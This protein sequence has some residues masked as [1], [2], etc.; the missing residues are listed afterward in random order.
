[1]SRILILRSG[2]DR[3]SIK[4]NIRVLVVTGVLAVLLATSSVLA[5]TSGSHPTSVTDVLGT[6]VAPNQSELALIVLEIRLPR[7][8]MAILVG[9]AL[10]SAGLI[11]QG[12]VR[13]PL[14]SPDVIGITSGASAAAV[15]FLHRFGP[16]RIHDRGPLRLDWRHPIVSAAHGQVLTAARWGVPSSSCTRRSAPVCSRPRGP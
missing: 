1:M 16:R 11:L 12:L 5:L 15:L 8:L 3:W 7:I 9:A 4:L 2:S 10:G 6:L 14:A 13:N